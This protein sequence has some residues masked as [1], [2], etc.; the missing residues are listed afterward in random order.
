MN[1]RLA[2]HIKESD[3]NDD[4]DANTREECTESH[5]DKITYTKI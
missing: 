1:A 4:H 5:E 3:E 2:Q